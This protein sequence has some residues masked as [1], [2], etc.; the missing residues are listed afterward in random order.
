MKKRHVIIVGGG[1][2][3]L[4]AAIT[5]AR[6]GAS[7]TIVEQKDRIGKKLLST[8]NGRCNLTNEYMDRHCFRGDDVTIVS[9]I[10]KQ[11]G[12][13]ETIAFFEALGVI[14]KNRQGYIYPIS[15]QAGTILD[16]LR[17]EIERL[18]ICVLTEEKVTAISKNAK[19][20]LIETNKNKLQGDAVIL[21]TGGKASPSLGS[22]G[23]GYQLAKS[24]GHTISPVVPALV[25][26][27]GNGNYFKQISGVRTQAKVTIHIDGNAVCD[28]TG[29]L[30]LTNYG[31]SGIP[32]FQVSRYAAKALYE[33]KSVVAELD[34][35]PTMS[36]EEFNAFITN[37]LV[38]HSEKTAEEFLIGIF[39][40][41]LIPLLLK[42]ATIPLQ[43]AMNTVRTEKMSQFLKICKHFEV[44]ITDTNGFEQAQV[45]AGGVRAAEV[46]F[47]TLES[48]YTD[49]LYFTGELLDIDGI[50]GG[51][52]LQW[53]W[54][55]GYVAGKHAA[56]GHEYDSNQSTEITTEPY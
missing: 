11:F 48:V 31:I 47:H 3:G 6:E 34:F 27:K 53:A 30:Q 39:H 55:T 2:S 32:V 35:L 4:V 10:L 38:L 43:I 15:D 13:G 36:D 18:D 44:E 28:D 19:G 37:R 46:D 49:D 22:D 12:Y 26:L 20:F 56:K 29:E 33:K 17:M 50:C 1:A 14:L 51:Y 45:C 42:T 5:A 23:S 16:V 21:A 52:N 41:K 24:L 8:G 9:D 54:S 25:Q 7:V 40:K